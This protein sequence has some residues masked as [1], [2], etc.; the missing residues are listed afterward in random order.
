MKSYS[1]TF[2]YL[3]NVKELLQL[4]DLQ[5]QASGAYVVLNVK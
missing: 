2:D 5:K 4:K 3:K 1:Y